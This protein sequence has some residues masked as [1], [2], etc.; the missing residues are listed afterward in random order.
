MAHKYDISAMVTACQLLI[1]KDL[2]T[3]NFVSAAVEGYLCK[4]D[5]LKNA[6]LSM[7]CK[8]LM[9]LRDIPN[10]ANL[11]KYPALSLEIAD[12]CF[13]VRP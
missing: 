2:S 13:L 1:I 4:D 11:E 6:A 10:W 8:E 7:M 5:E 12:R 9:P 3:A